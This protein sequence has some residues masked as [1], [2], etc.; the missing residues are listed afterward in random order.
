MGEQARLESFVPL[1]GFLRR[2]DRKPHIKDGLVSWEAFRPRPHEPSL[3]F[4]FQ[5]DWL[6]TEEGLR[7]YQIDNAL[8][9][10]DLPGVCKLTFHNLTELVHPPLPP[11]PQPAPEDPRYGD[12]HCVTDVPESQEH[13]EA[14]ARL[15]TRNTDAGLPMSFVKKGKRPDMFPPP[16][17]SA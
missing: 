17:A 4:T 1:D 13:M 8:K 10:G 16:R 15:A 7:Q 14:L 5:T 12:L 2:T 3:S 9:F 6:A 11:R